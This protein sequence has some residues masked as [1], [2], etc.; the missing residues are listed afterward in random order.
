MV[1]E[2]KKLL[3]DII[4]CLENIENYIGENKVFTEYS[5]NFLLQ[6]AVERNLITLGEAMNLLLKK[7]PEIPISN[8]RRIVDTR[9]RLTHGYDEIEV[10]QIWNI[11]INHLPL[12]KTEVEKLL[13]N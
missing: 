12:L 7:E 6:D 1:L 5:E 8:A 2:V 3:Q 10:T 4:I 11:V 9:N 13:E